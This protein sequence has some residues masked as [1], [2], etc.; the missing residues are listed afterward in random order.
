M[1][2]GVRIA[3]LN[4]RHGRLGERGLDPNDFLGV[5]GGLCSVLAQQLEHAGEVVGIVGADVDVAL[6]GIQI[7][8]AIRQGQSALT[9]SRDDRS[10]VLEV[11]LG[12]KPKE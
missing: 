11:L 7:V 10:T 9:H 6:V 12:A 8:V 3:H 2:V 1:I 4:A 5:R